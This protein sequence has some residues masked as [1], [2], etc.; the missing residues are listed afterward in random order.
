[1]SWHALGGIRLTCLMTCLKTQVDYYTNYVFRAPTPGIRF[2]D[3]VTIAIDDLLT[4]ANPAHLGKL[5]AISPPEPRHALVFAIARD[6]ANGMS[7]DDLLPWKVLATSVVITF[8]RVFSDDSIFCLATDAREL[9]G[10]R[11]EVMAYSA[12]PPC[13]RHAH[14]HE[15]THTSTHTHTHTRTHTHTHLHLPT[16]TCTM[17]HT[18]RGAADLSP[19]HVQGQT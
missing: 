11:C 15:H 14:V 1:M 16:T 8:T 19:L 3:R 2:S 5:K 18:S 10:H 7:D 12:V 9:V 17:P 4:P 13:V 6:I